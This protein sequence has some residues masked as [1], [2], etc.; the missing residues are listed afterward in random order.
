MVRIISKEN[1]FM[2]KICTTG[3]NQAHTYF[4]SLPALFEVILRGQTGKV[5]K[6]Y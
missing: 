3:G 1:A 2:F 5:I 4:G 6:T